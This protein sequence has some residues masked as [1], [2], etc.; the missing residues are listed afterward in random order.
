M[1]IGLSLKEQK[2]DVVNQQIREI[3]SGRDNA[4][5]YVTL[6]VNETSTV[7]DNPN[8]SATS[9]VQLTPATADAAAAAA[10]TYVPESTVVSGSFTI[11]HASAASSDRTFHYRIHGGH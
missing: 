7:V 5:G 3:G 4:S 11:Q 1:P 10:T 9:N 2:G 6:A 8:C